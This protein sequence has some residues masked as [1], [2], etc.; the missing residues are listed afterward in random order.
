MSDGHQS[1]THRLAGVDRVL[2]C[3]RVLAREPRGIALEELARKLDSPKS[4]IHRALG[5][6]N[7]AGLVEQQARGRYRLSLDFV[8]LAFS[9]YDDLDRVQ[10]VRPLLDELVAMFD[11][12]AHY[13]ERAGPDVV[14]IARANPAAQRVQMSSTIGGRYPASCTALGKALLA[15]SLCDLESV[16]H[17]I[18]EYGS[19]PQRTQ[20]SIVTADALSAELEETRRRGY[21]VDRE[22]NDP[23]I[24]CISFAV[25]LDAHK[26]TGAISISA[27]AAMTPLSAL[28]EKAD[29]VRATIRRRL[30]D[31]SVKDPT[32][33]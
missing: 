29:E 28:T 31:A 6:L 3:I 24:N 18:D 32:K 4:S 14:Y 8:R 1:D 26:P 11:E 13:A 27:V 10:L 25:F 19:L 33:D 12:T 20:S 16:R 15:Y 30:G 9:Y 22:E 21:A 2:T 23:G 5:A 17:Y 7:R